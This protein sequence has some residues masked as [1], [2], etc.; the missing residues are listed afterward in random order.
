MIGDEDPK[1]ENLSPTTD[2]FYNLVQRIPL[3][4]EAKKIWS[5]DLLMAFNDADG[6][7]P[8]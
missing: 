3:K 7:Y 6:L 5:S 2:A 8:E 1:L 4:I